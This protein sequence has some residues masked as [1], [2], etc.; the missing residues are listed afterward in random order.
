[1]GIGNAENFEQALQRAVLAGPA[2]Q[3][4]KRDIGLDSGQ[5]R[6]DIAADIDRR[7]AIIAA[8]ERFGA[9]LAGAQRYFALGRPAPHQNGDMLSHGS[10]GSLAGSG[11]SHG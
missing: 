9:S 4:I 2:V 10:A 8:A 3:D 11:D 5:R 6:G 7:N 1:M